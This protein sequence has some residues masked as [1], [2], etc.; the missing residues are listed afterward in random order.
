MALKKKFED[1]KFVVEVV[2]YK[3]E[4]YMR[5]IAKGAQIV[6]RLDSNGVNERTFRIPKR[7]EDNQR[8]P[9]AADY[10]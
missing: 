7:P 3:G 10:Q 6:D 9:A 8:V 2:D 5:L 4:E 1:E